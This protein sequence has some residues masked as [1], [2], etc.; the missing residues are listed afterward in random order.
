MDQTHSIIIDGRPRTMN[1]HEL[2]ALAVRLYGE[3]TDAAKSHLSASVRLGVVL[4]QAKKIHARSFLA[5]LKYNH[6][7]QKTSWRAMRNA[8][9][10]GDSQ[11]NLDTGKL[12]AI[13]HAA[14]PAQFP[15]RAE[16]SDRQVSGRTLEA[17][18]N[19]Q[20]GTS[21]QTD[22][23][24]YSPRA[25]NDRMQGRGGSEA[26]RRGAEGTQRAAEG[27]WDEEEDGEGVEFDSGIYL[28]GVEDEDLG[29]VGDEADEVPVVPAGRLAPTSRTGAP[30]SSGVPNGG[31]FSGGEQ[32]TLAALYE[33]AQAELSELVVALDEHEFEAEEVRAISGFVREMLK[34]RKAVRT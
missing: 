14:F 20:H 22:T 10:L 34:R 15:S 5:W 32:M 27:S 7:S 33:E 3:V 1:V 29:D 8:V 21:S 18:L 11:G 17:A 28:D 6:I 19:H 31:P 4:L 2:T 16:F 24:A 25:A 12:F 9:E 26:E 13:V 23:G 30:R